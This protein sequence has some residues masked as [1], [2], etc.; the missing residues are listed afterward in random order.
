MT[1]TVLLL[2]CVVTWLLRISFITLVPAGGLPDRLRSAL[3]DVGPAVLAAVVVTHLAHGE[4]LQGL[5][6]TDL[7][8]TLV[9]A[10]VAWRTRSLSLT[11][12]VGVLAVGVLRAVL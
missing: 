1:A 4:G 8:A 5:I 6:L 9:A 11:V 10:A 3:D 12:V 7:L 2:A